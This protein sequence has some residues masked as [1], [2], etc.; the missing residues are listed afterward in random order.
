M[1]FHDFIVVLNISQFALF[2][3]LATHL[4]WLTEVAIPNCIIDSVLLNDELFQAHVLQIFLVHTYV[5]DIDARKLIL[6][7]LIL[8]LLILGK[9]PE[10]EAI[11]KLFLSFTD[12]LSESLSHS[13]SHALQKLR[14]LHT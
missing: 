7:P 5:S 12:H 11:L 6:R 3:V 10:K 4:E 8:D 9:R 2:R 14:L 13:V 1:L